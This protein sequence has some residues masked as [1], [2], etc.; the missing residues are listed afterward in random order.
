MSDNKDF[1]L[2]HYSVPVQTVTLYS[3]VSIVTVFQD[4]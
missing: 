2:E 4:I 3:S 1:Q